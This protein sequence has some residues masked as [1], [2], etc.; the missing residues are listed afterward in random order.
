MSLGIN[1]RTG[2]GGGCQVMR[3]FPTCDLAMH[4]QERTDCLLDGI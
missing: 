3:W 4:T 1:W 2:I